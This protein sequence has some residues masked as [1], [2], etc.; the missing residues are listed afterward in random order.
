VYSAKE[1]GAEVVYVTDPHWMR[2]R[3]A[4]EHAALLDT[5]QP[6]EERPERSD[7]V[8]L[9]RS[10]YDPLER[11]ESKDFGPFFDALAE[12][13]V[14]TTPVGEA[15]GKQAV[16][17]YFTHAAATLEFDPF[18]RPLAY[19]AD[20]NRVVQLGEETWIVKATGE[21]T[22]GD[23]WAWVFDVVDGRIKRIL[24]IQRLAGVA[25]EIAEALAK[26]QKEAEIS[27]R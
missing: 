24:A 23:A 12:D 25:D 10:I 19:F 11:G 18:V 26:A 13:V 4:S 9:L 3:A 2:A 21:T 8:A 22:H 5:L 6:S 14:L 20:G 16:I 17:G 27:E 15:R 7:A 1:E